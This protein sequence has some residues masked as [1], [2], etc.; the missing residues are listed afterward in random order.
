MH[1]QSIFFLIIFSSIYTGRWFS[2]PVLRLAFVLYGAFLQILIIYL[3][4]S[5]DGMNGKNAQEAPIE[6]NEFSNGL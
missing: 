2:D 3:L 5:S 1:Y 6:P 4:F